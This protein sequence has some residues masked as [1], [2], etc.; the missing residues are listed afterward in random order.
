MY[1]VEGV[2]VL[3]GGVRIGWGRLEDFSL[4]VPITTK[5]HTSYD[6]MK[7]KQKSSS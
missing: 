5:L 1:A 6:K 4:K 3:A 7:N 2:F